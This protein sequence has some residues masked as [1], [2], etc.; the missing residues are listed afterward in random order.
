MS[1]TTIPFVSPVL[2]Q[3]TA[4]A[5]AAQVA[6]KVSSEQIAAVV[7]ACSAGAD[8]AA[9]VA[10]LQALTKALT[11]ANPAASLATIVGS[12]ATQLSSV[13][14]ESIAGKITIDIANLTAA[15]ETL[16]GIAKSNGLADL[17]TILTA[18]A[19]NVKNGVAID[20]PAI[21]SGV[22]VTLPNNPAS[23]A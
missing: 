20:L 16:V 9:C 1:S 7:N 10:A 5:S 3:A 18:I 23:P 14:N 4:P 22:G 19:E 6:V 15:I 21:A 8:S 11:I 12:I 13:S 2:A 17:A